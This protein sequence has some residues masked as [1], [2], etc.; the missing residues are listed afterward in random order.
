MS[1]SH[2]SDLIR[3]RLFDGAPTTPEELDDA[4]RVATEVWTWAEAHGLDRVAAIARGLVTALTV[5][6]TPY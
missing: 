6:V 2:F 1:S 4:I 3:A 5:R